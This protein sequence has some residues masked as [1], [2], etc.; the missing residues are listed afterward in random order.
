MDAELLNQMVR[1]KARLV[2]ACLVGCIE[3]IEDRVPTDEEVALFGQRQL[4]HQEEVYL[5]KGT[6]IVRVIYWPA[7]HKPYEVH[8][9]VNPFW[10]IKC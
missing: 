6:V 7:K 2:E 4:S 9:I 3:S 5:W 1:E 10:P 8:S